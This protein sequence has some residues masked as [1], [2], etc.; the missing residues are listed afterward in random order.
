VGTPVKGAGGGISRLANCV[1]CPP[2]LKLNQIQ[3]P[4]YKKEFHPDR[5]E[6]FGGREIWDTNPFQFVISRAI[7][8]SLVS[9]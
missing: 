5:S 3:I 2:K 9:L 6:I 1:R 7:P 8:L 4:K